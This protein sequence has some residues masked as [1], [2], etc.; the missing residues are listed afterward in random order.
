MNINI[1]EQIKDQIPAGSYIVRTEVL[2]GFVTVV[3]EYNGERF[4]TKFN[5]RMFYGKEVSRIHYMEVVSKF[6]ISYTLDTGDRFQK[7]TKEEFYARARSG[8]LWQ[9]HRRTAN[10][11][12][13]VELVVHKEEI[14]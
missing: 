8:A 9:K 7:I 3:Y 11:Q 1:K 12:N 6:P 5:M 14:E 4:R 13:M 10:K 2:N